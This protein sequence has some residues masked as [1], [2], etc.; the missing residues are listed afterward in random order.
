MIEYLAVG[1]TMPDLQAC[2]NAHAREGWTFKQMVLAPM[3]TSRF[4]AEQIPGLLVLFERVAKPKL[5]CPA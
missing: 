3:Q 5:T 4:E 2:C 1:C